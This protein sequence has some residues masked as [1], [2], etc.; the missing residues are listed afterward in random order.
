MYICERKWITS[1]MAAASMVVI[2]VAAGGLAG[3]GD[4]DG[5]TPSDGGRPDAS[6]QDAG[7][8]DASASDAGTSDGGVCPTPEALWDDI[9]LTEFT[10]LPALEELGAEGTFTLADPATYWELRRGR[11]D[12]FEVITSQGE[13]CSEAENTEVCSAEFDDMLAASGFGGSCLPGLCFGYVAVNREN[14]SSL[15]ITPEELVTFLGTIDSPSE[16]ALIAFAHGY[17]WDSNEASAGSAR[18]SEQG[19]ELLVTELVQDCDP[20]VTDRVQVQVS[21]AGELTVLRRQILRVNCNACI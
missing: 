8:S 1:L 2:G 21:P 20:I 6:T 7:A 9:D 3:C 14:T 19:F 12:S 15:I 5:P 16:A 11:P 4:D 13:K 10:A 18:V 17:Y